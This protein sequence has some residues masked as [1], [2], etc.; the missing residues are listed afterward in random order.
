MPDIFAHCL[1][2]V[3]AGRCV[4]GNWKLYLLAVVLSTLPDLDGLT[5]LHRSLL[6]S[7]LFLA[8]LSFAIFLTLKQRKYPV[9]TASLLACLPFL[10]CLMD[11][12]T[13][14]IPIKLFYPISNTGYQFAHI[15]DTFIEALFSISPYVYYLEA[16]RV[17]LILLT[18]TLLMVALNNA[19]KNHK[20]STHLA[21]DRQ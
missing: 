14:S 16:T 12:L 7:L 9:K 2:G 13:G 18:T 10:H 19:T 6:H 21:P 4:N 3:V 11:L 20:N 15:V 1:V 5:P 17:D 8:P